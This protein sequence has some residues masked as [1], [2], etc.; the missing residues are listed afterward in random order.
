MKHFKKLLAIATLFVLCMAPLLGDPMIAHAE[1]SG[2]TYYLKYVPNLNQ[3]RYQKDSWQQDKE[4]WD[5]NA[6]KANIKDGDLLVIDGTNG[7]GIDLTVDVRLSNLTV[8]NGDLVLVTATSVDN[9]YGLNGTK[10]VVNGNV[11]NA[12]VYEQSLANFNNNVTNLTVSSGQY[13]TPLAT[14][15]VLG[16]CDY[17]CIENGMKAYSFV[18]NTLRLV[19]GNFTTEAKNYSTT[20]PATTP[21]V[22]STSNDEYDDVPK[23]GDARFN[24]LWLVGLAAVCF[25]GS[26]GIRKMK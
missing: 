12:Y 25:A 20:A 3:F 26:V 9:F 22:P 17:F 5:V 2:T 23:T 24:P 10:T 19:D 11:T 14:V 21:A 16:T 7:E 13:A 18:A 4:H 8:V 15:S 6:L 1:E